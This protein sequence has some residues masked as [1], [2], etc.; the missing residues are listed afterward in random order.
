MWRHPGKTMFCRDD[1]TLGTRLVS[2]KC[3]G[4]DQFEDYAVQ[5]Q[6]ARD[7][8]KQKAT[9]QGGGLCGGIQ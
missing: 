6:I 1:A 3:M 7:L 9:C 8:M 5:L 4:A 2:K